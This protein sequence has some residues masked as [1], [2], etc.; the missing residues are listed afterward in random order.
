MYFH[1]RYNDIIYR[2]K[3]NEKQLTWYDVKKDEWSTIA[4]TLCD[5]KCMFK[6][7]ENE[8]ELYCFSSNSELQKFHIQDQTWSELEDY[9]RQNTKD[10]N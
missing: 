9:N 6:M 8:N 3:P 4:L 10:S 1:D 5:I 2:A 7:E